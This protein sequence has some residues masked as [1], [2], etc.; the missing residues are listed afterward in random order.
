MLVGKK[1]GIGM[2]GRSF[3]PPHKGHL[4]IYS[5]SLKKIKLKKIYWIKKK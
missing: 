5:N 1:K 4:K 3:E 2:L